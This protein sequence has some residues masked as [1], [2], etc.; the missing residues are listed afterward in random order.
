MATV[1]IGIGSNLGEREENCRNAIKLL[2]ESGIKVL[3]QSSKIE[4]EPWGVTDQPDFIN[5]AIMVETDQKPLALLHLL[6]NIET[7]AGR[8]PTTRWGPRLIDLDILLYDD[9]ILNTPELEIP[10]PMMC[11]RE[12][13]LKPL[14]E[15]GPDVIH[16]VFRKS[17]KGLLED[18]KS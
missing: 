9:L 5:M 1:Y 3:R 4:T 7:D 13:V 15:I 11:D 18:R 6:K 10:H 14:A 12:F 8:R 17:I 2:I 16:P